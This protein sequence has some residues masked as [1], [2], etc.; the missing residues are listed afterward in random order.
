[1]KK[2]IIVIFLVFLIASVGWAGNLYHY[3][4]NTGEF[5]GSTTA[6]LD[7]L[8]TIKQGKNIY[9]IPGNATDQIPPEAQANE[10]AI[11]QDNKWLLISD[12]RGAIYYKANGTKITI[13]S[14]GQIVPQGALLEPPP[15][16]TLP[17][18][19][20]QLDKIKVNAEIRKMA[21]ESLKSQ[22]KI[23]QSYTED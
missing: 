19:Q 10:K 12:F 8:E 17:L 18:T 23:S 2:S 15:P 5:L 9:L 21:I 13:N 22:G 4:K 7:P 14:L 1:M 6:R 20:N 16:L 11:Y 3:H